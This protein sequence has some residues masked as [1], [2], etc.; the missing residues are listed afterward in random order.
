MVENE[1]RA[2]YCPEFGSAFCECPHYE[3]QCNDAWS[4]EDMEFIVEDIILYYDTNGDNAI[5]P[6]DAIDEEHYGMLIDNCDFD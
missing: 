2:E 5:N 1:W 6:E 3:P 4:C